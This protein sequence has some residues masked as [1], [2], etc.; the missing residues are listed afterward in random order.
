M[1]GLQNSM[2]NIGGVVGPI[3]TDAIVGAAGSLTPALISSVA[4]IDLAVLN[5]L[6]LLDKVELINFEPTPETRHLHDQHNA[7]TR[8]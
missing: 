1:V 2:S 6:S 4:L 7:D 5:Y 8:A 3:V